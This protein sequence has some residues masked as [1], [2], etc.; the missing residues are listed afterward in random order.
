MVPP[1]ASGVGGTDSVN[2]RKRR[3]KAL[4]PPPTDGPAKPE[5]GL[6]QQF[7]GAEFPDDSF[8][9]P[10]PRKERMRREDTVTSLGSSIPSSEKYYARA[11]T[12]NS[13][14]SGKSQGKDSGSADGQQM[15]RAES[16]SSIISQ[17]VDLSVGKGS[18]VG[19]L[20]AEIGHMHPDASSW[21]RQAYEPPARLSEDPGRKQR[22]KSKYGDENF[23]TDLQKAAKPKSA[24]VDGKEEILEI[25]TRPK[26]KQS[27]GRDDED[28]RR[29]RPKSRQSDSREDEETSRARSKSRAPDSREERE[30]R[31]KS[32]GP[33]SRDADDDTRPPR[34]KS[35]QAER[36]EESSGK[37]KRKSKDTPE[38]KAE[39]EERR[40]STH[41]GDTRKSVEQMEKESRK[42]PKSEKLEKASKTSSSKS[43]SREDVSP[44]SFQEK[45]AR[46]TSVLEV[47]AASQPSQSR[48]SQIFP[49]SAA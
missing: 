21:L 31:S 1:T 40:K 12:S 5:V 30:P 35:R 38:A 17:P 20:L 3:P 43:S 29:A 7:E 48:Q 44:E 41:G 19:D 13:V 28:D 24:H 14:G 6:G 34:S 45:A 49:T 32:R 42:V 8:P 2:L 27:E 9:Q 26:S 37:S 33:E 15:R 16:E 47:T 23:D 39:K 10:P 25:R 11:D 36:E 22:P 46:R 18:N 4:P